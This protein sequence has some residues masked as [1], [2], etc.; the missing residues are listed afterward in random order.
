LKTT[1][2]LILQLADDSDFYYDK[3]QNKK[4][5]RVVHHEFI[6]SSEH[7]IL[8]YTDDDVIN[9]SHDPMII[10]TICKN[11]DYNIRILWNNKLWRVV[12]TAV[13]EMY[14]AMREI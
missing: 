8:Y 7:L 11:D 13:K 3:L 12:S 10:G 9:P 1:S 5:F 4:C 6:K 2:T 14:S